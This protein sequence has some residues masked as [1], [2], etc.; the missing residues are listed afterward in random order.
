MNKNNSG[1]HILELELTNKCNLDCIHCYVDKSKTSELSYEVVKKVIKEASNLD[2]YRLVFT[3]GEPLIYPKLFQAAK[4]AKKLGIRNL[5]LLTN[6][7]LV[8]KSNIN[9]LTIFDGIQLSLD[10][11][12]SHNSLRKN[13]T[14]ALENTISLLKQKKIK[15]NL[16]C[17]L[18]KSNIDKIEQIIEYAKKLKVRLGFNTLVVLDPS[19]ESQRLSPLE[20]KSSLTLIMKYISKGY[21][22]DLSHH[23]RFLVDKQRMME[24]NTS[25]NV[26]SNKIHG[27]CLAGIAALY[28]CCDGTVLAC[29]FLKYPCDNIYK[30]NLSDIWE[31]NK[32]LNILRDRKK[33]EGE[34]G[35]CKYV[36]VC[37]GCRAQSYLK[38]NKINSSETGCFLNL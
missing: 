16:Y 7:I 38:H 17:T 29:P 14:N 3:G 15:I 8:N 4:Y 20:V 5:Y 37:G 35:S 25:I 12:P 19:L 11:V 23:L 13:Y 36:N 34:C 32:F 31:N 22:V 9:N 33:F 18:C 1:L 10:D 6:G 2:V 26:N 24:F 28:I 27:G 21:K 30:N